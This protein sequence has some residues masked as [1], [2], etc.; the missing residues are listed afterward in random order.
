MPSAGVLEQNIPY[1][2]GPASFADSEKKTAMTEK[3]VFAPPKGN[4]GKMKEKSKVVANRNPQRSRKKGL[5]PHPKEETLKS[6]KSCLQAM[7]GDIRLR[8]WKERI[9]V[10]GGKKDI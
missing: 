7:E 5:V 3:E 8:A 6:K 2:G 9:A 10:Q 1:A 4:S